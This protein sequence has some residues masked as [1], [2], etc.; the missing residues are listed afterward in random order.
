MIDATILD[1]PETLTC[2]VI[3]LSGSIR[4]YIGTKQILN[5]ES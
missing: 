4:K 5:P 3:I 1:L 2:G